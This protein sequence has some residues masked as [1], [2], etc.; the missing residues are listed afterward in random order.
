MSNAFLSYLY[1]KAQKRK[2]LEPKGEFLLWIHYK[3]ISDYEIKT[4]GTPGT[5]PVYFLHL[6]DP[7]FLKLCQN[8]EGGNN[9]WKVFIKLS[10][11]SA[12]ESDLQCFM[13]NSAFLA[14]GR[15]CLVNQEVMEKWWIL[16]ARAISLE[17]L[18]PLLLQKS[19]NAA[20]DKKFQVLVF[21]S[22]Q[23]F[24]WLELKGSYLQAK[25]HI[26]EYLIAQI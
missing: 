17:M 10:R 8:H 15:K 16:F 9:A 21:D 25:Q 22:M 5:Q 20:K 7:F 14:A 3:L 24:S 1:H 11:I 6:R 12:F 2:A 23:E 13:V 19:E 4:K 18:S 26:S